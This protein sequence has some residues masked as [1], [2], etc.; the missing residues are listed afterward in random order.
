MIHDDPHKRNNRVMI[1]KP[2]ETTT[3]GQTTTAWAD[4]AYAYVGIETLSGKEYWEAQRHE[5][6]ATHLLTGTWD[7]FENVTADFRIAFGSRTFQL[8]EPPRN[9]DEADVVAKVQ[10]EEATR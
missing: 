5:S 8:T 9:I 2:T 7:D 6:S 10:A 1:Q 4:F 3:A